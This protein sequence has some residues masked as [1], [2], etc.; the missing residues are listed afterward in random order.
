MGADM[1]IQLSGKPA[2]RASTLVPHGGRII[3]I[4]ARHLIALIAARL[5][6]ERGGGMGLLAAGG[7]REQQAPGA[8]IAV[9]LG[10][11]SFAPNSPALQGL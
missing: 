9:G 10:R 2:L 4:D 8:G 11:G 1:M 7:G 5:C 3:Q 6:K